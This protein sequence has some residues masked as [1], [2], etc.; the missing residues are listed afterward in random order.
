MAQQTNAIRPTL[1]RPEDQPVEGWDDSRGRLTWAT[2]F[3]AARTPT[4]TFNAGVATIEPGGFLAAHRHTPS[5]LY[6]VLEGRAKITIDGTTHDVAAGTGV[7]IPGNAEHAIRNEGE[8]PVRFLFAFASDRF[9][10]VEYV[11]S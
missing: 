4:D 9:D 1:A 5:E 3:D 6:F 7:F 2:L 8:A 10:T 11:F